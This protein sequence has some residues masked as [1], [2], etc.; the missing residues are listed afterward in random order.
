M[1]SVLTDSQNLTNMV[2]RILLQFFRMLCYFSLTALA[3]ATWFQCSCAGW[4]C[5]V[6]EHQTV[7]GSHEDLNAALV[8]DINVLSPLAAL[9]KP[10]VFRKRDQENC[11]HRLSVFPTNACVL[12]CATTTRLSVIFACARGLLLLSLRAII[13][14]PF[15]IHKTQ[16]VIC[17]AS[18]KVSLFR[19]VFYCVY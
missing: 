8:I 11:R 2:K 19:Q 10:R 12:L 9:A 3:A 5:A 15:S 1:I 7:A 17:I 6:A 16:S 18:A 14:F 4:C 13:I